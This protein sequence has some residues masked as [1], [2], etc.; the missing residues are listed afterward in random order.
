M[1]RLMVLGLLWHR[2]MTG[3]ELQ[4]TLQVSQTDKWAGILPGSIY[5]ALKK[6]HQE[7]LVELEAVEQTG[8][9][10][11]TSYRITDRGQEE[12]V[13][14]AG[15][16]LREKSVVFPTTLY[17]ALSFLHLVPRQAIRTALQEQ[18]QGLE[19]DYAA[20]RQGQEMKEEVMKLS[21]EALLV[22]ENIYAQY[23]L[24]LEFLGKLEEIYSG[25]EEEQG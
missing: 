16:G 4:Q 23:E 8:N 21:R 22:F 24:Q 6:L 7:G 5:H 12:A 1:I 20:M 18:R 3:Y 17:T 25:T 2:P 11:R 14:L 19:A 13:R 10:S 9:R 15:E